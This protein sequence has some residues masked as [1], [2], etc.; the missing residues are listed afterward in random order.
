VLEDGR[1]GSGRA[2]LEA[3][4][5]PENSDGGI[6]ALGLAVDHDPDPARRKTGVQQSQ[7][8]AD[9][10]VVGGRSGLNWSGGKA[11]STVIVVDEDQIAVRVVTT[12]MSPVQRAATDD[13]EQ[14]CGER[15]AGDQ[16]STSAKHQIAL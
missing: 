14:Q 3:R 7:R 4:G 8:V 13:E 10:A 5:V 12:D 11:V 9:E 2:P 6:D 15:T 1:R 16:V